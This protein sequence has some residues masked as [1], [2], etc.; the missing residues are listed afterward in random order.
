M[1][2]ALIGVKIIWNDTPLKINSV[3]NTIDIYFFFK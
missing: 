1:E 2:V 3:L